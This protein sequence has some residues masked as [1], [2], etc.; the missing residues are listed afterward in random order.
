MLFLYAI[1]LG[2]IAEYNSVRFEKIYVLSKNSLSV[3]QTQIQRLSTTV[4][5]TVLSAII[6]GLQPF[7]PL[8][9]LKEKY[10][11]VSR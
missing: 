1:D 3:K 5:Y 8:F 9:W 2:M 7:N 6:I 4:N 10:Y 11:T